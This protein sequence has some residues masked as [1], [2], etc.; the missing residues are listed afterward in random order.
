ME[1]GSG[2]ARSGLLAT[3]ENA[4]APSACSLRKW[5]LNGFVLKE[6]LDAEKAERF[7]EASSIYLQDCA[8]TGADPIPD[9]FRHV[10][11][12]CE[13]IHYLS[14]YKYIFEA[15]IDRAKE[16]FRENIRNSINFRFGDYF[17]D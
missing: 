3:I 4:V 2:E 13:H 11:P 7:I 10:M 12:E 8:Y 17:K 9:Y 16:E 1:F 14:K 6:R 5:L 15:T